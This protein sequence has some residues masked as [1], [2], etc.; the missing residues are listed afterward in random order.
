MVYVVVAL[1]FA[2]FT[3]MSALLHFTYYN[4]RIVGAQKLRGI[5]SVCG[6]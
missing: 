6:G 4:E 3:Y 2:V 1:F 5:N